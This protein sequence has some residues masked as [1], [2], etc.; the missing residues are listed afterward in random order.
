MSEKVY[1]PADIQTALKERLKKFEIQ[2]KDLSAR[3]LR[4]DEHMEPGIHE[5]GQPGA[6]Q[7]IEPGGHENAVM[8]MP[9]SPA[10]QPV[11]SSHG[12][13]QGQ[14]QDLCPMCGQPDMPGQC[15]CL[16]GGGNEG[17]DPGIIDAGAAG[18]PSTPLN[19]SED[20]LA[21]SECEHGKDCK[22]CGLKK[23]ADFINI[24]G[25]K[26]TKGIHPDAKLPPGDDQ[27]LPNK[28]KSK[29]VESQDDN[30][31][32]E[33][34]QGLAKAGPPMAKPPSGG[35][36]GAVAPAPVA[37]AKAPKVAGPAGGPK[38]LGKAALNMAGAA[39]MAGVHAA[40]DSFKAAGKGGAP[41]VKPMPTAGAHAD[42][43]ATFGSAMAGDY[44]PKGPVSSGLELAG[45]PKMA[46]PG[47]LVG[48]AEE[49]PNREKIFG[50]KYKKDKAVADTKQTQDNH[51]KEAQAV[52]NG[53]SGKPWL[54]KAAD[55]LSKSLGAC[56]H[57]GNEEHAG[58]CGL[59]KN[60]KSSLI[61][62]ASPLFTA[63]PKVKPAAAGLGHVSNEA[64]EKTVQAKTTADRGIAPT[65]MADPKR[66]AVKSEETK[67]KPTHVCAA[68][69]CTKGIS[70][71]SEYC[72]AHKPPKGK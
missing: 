33:N 52:R 1:T 72:K 49:A 64:Q 12:I 54:K 46:A 60:I 45:K 55:E 16:N 37:A 56:L 15:T 13:P 24:D 5:A 71:A 8:P 20:E 29:K 19:L 42:R 35:P 26:E 39:K 48:K 14:L 40:V 3:E 68:P 67:A 31:V 7:H 50:D 51:N 57:C 53:T 27:V 25:K 43:A 34:S 41:A 17:L 58:V 2:L 44:Q 61:K 32:K 10:E 66:L 9:Q 21:L 65:K 69:L 22:S 62:V 70:G 38:G 23:D 18:V 28:K 63:P 6:E 11:G 59:A 47:R 4:K 30:E 36:A